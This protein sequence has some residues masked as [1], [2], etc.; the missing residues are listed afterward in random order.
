M[1]ENPVYAGA[2]AEWEE[3]CRPRPIPLDER[4]DMRR[5]DHCRE[6]FASDDPD[7]VETWAN[8]YCGEGCYSW[9]TDEPRAC[10]PRA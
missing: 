1:L 3:L 8:W 2:A 9:H 6:Y 5:C 7:A 4:E 10:E